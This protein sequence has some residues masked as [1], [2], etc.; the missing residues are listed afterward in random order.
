[1]KNTFRLSFYL[2][3]YAINA[4]CASTSISLIATLLPFLVIVKGATENSEKS[5]DIFDMFYFSSLIF[6]VIAPLQS[7]K[8]SL[9]DGVSSFSIGPTQGIYF[10]N[11]FIFIS[12]VVVTLF[13]ICFYL[14]THRKASNRKYPKN[15]N[16][17]F[18]PQSPNLHI[19]FFFIIISFLLFVLASGGL[20]NV[21]SP[22]FEK[23][24]ENTSNTAIIFLAALSSFSFIFINFYTKLSRKDKI[25]YFVHLLAT[26]TILLISSNPLT[27]PRFMLIGCWLPVLM[28]GMRGSLNLKATY[29]ILFVSLIIVLPILSLTTRMGISGIYDSEYSIAATDIFTTP[30]ADVFD[31]LVYLVQYTDIHGFTLGKNTLGILTFY[32]PREIWTGKP[33]LIAIEIGSELVYFA[34]AGTSNLSSFYGGEMY[35]DFSFL[36]PLAGGLFTGYIFKRIT[37]WKITSSTLNNERIPTYILMAAVPIVLRGP[38]MATAGLVFFQL[39]FFYICNNSLTKTKVAKKN[40]YMAKN[41]HEH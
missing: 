26:I 24:S 2:L 23:E 4:V 22:R 13:Y 35:M 10:D 32:I 25:K 27:T 12:S 17:S 15:P 3:I 34:F 29:I 39:V 6:F 36:G 1:M 21:F 14:V 11:K 33:D 31:M 37:N 8:G 20:S 9:T 41:N 40:I 16:P 28:I 30:Y 19:L 38:F 18:F 7:I 5:F